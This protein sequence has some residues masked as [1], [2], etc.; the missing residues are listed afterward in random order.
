MRRNSKQQTSNSKHQTANIQQQAANNALVSQD[1][2]KE[3]GHCW[4]QL[5][6][7]L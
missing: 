3:S 5:E 6:Q 7:Q 1:V 2:Q 4:L